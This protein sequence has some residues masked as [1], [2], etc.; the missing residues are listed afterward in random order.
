MTTPIVVL[1]TNWG[2]KHGGLNSFNIDLCTHLAGILTDKYKV[3]CVVLNADDS[4]IEDARGRGVHLLS[5]KADNT[6][7]DSAMAAEVIDSI[8]ESYVQ[9]AAWWVGHDIFTGP[10]AVKAANK[11]AGSRSAVLLHMDYK[12]YYVFKSGQGKSALEKGE[13][14][15]KVLND[16]DLVMAVGPN[17]ASVAREYVGPENKGK[18]VELIPGLSEVQKIYSPENFSAITF[19]RFVEGNEVIKQVKLA[20][21]AFAH[22]LKS[23]RHLFITSSPDP[24]FTVFGL[25]DGNLKEENTDLIKLA[26][27]YADRL[28]T[29]N[30]VPYLENRQQLFDQLASH[31]VCLI[32]S[33]HEGFGLA[34]LEA[35]SAEVP[36]ILSRA[37]GLYKFISE[38]LGKPGLGCLFEVDIKGA[39]DDPYFRPE[40]LEA[41]VNQ[42]ARIKAD[43][44]AAKQG[45]TALKKLLSDRGFTWEQTATQLAKACNLECNPAMGH[46]GGQAP[47]ER[48]TTPTGEGCT[49]PAGLGLLAR[50][51]HPKPCKDFTGRRQDLDRF[52]QAFLEYPFVVIEG[53]GGTGKTEFVT[54]CLKEFVDPERAVWFECSAESRFDLLIEASGYHDLLQGEKSDLAKYSGFTDLIERD[55]KVLFIDNYQD[56]TD[57]SLRAAFLFAARRLNQARVVLITRTHPNL[58]EIQYTPVRL[59]GLN[60]VNGDAFEFAKKLAARSYSH[61]T[62]QD[63]L[64]NGVC[65]KLAGHPLAIQL[66]LQLLSYGQSP[67]NILKSIVQD[68]NR[69]EDLSKRLL[70]IIFEHPK[71]TEQEKQFMLAFSVF[72]LK[73]DRLAIEALFEEVDI[74]VPLHGLID[75]L[76]ITYSPADC[77]YETHPLIREFCY[78]RLPEKKDFH[79]KAASHFASRR[80]PQFNPA[81]EERIYH[82]HLKSEIWFEIAAT[83]A[84]KG[85]E[86]V[87][88]GHTGILTEM[89]TVARKN[90]TDLAEFYLRE[91]DI[92][93]I[94]GEWNKALKCFETAFSCP[95]V[96]EA[97]TAEAYTKYGIIL[98][99]KGETRAAEDYFMEALVN[100]TQNNDRK[101]KALCLNSIGAVNEIYGN[102]KEAEEN[103]AAAFEI[104]QQIGDRE[105]A[106]SSLRSLGGIHATK[107]EIDGALTQ[108]RKSLDICEKIGDRVGIGESINCIGSV[109]LSKGDFDDALKK[110]IESLEIEKEIGDKSGISTSLNSVGLVLYSKGEFDGALEKFT[111][112]LVIDKEIGNK[113]G[114]AAS[115][116]NIGLVLTAKGDYDDAIKKYTE[117][118]AIV[119]DIG[120]KFGIATSLHNIGAVLRQ[121]NDA[122]G[123]LKKF[124]ESLEIVTEIGDRS[125]IAA[126]LN[127]IGLVLHS[128][129]NYDGAL[130]KFNESLEIQKRIGNKSAIA[131]YL[132]NIGLVLDSKGDSEG[133]LIKYTESLELKKEI[134]SR[135]TMTETYHNIGG[136]YERKSQPSS[137]IEMF[138]LCHALK[139]QM[140]MPTKNSLKNILRIRQ[141][142]KNLKQFTSIVQEAY[143]KIPVELQPFL[144]IDEL[145]MDNTV[146]HEIGER[147]G[148]NDP[149]PCGSG[150]KYKKCCQKEH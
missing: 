133:A 134:G 50:T 150:K 25:T 119:K 76:M 46:E 142:S 42:L 103:I 83:V 85:E 6:R 56:V 10:V 78:D 8:R 91:G 94:R 39:A 100:C 7:F 120:N 33:L 89:I 40:D 12:A 96:S 106:A 135:S 113:S 70:D 128:K 47:L 149:C 138:L 93:N 136:I 51:V 109:L 20:V 5:I 19:G 101:G 23:H 125:A 84:G 72:Q 86:F 116:N 27:R 66:A 137:A 114:I 124:T 3:V 14:Q 4:E 126:S 43:Y 108:Y 13:E 26:E 63:D 15:K 61:L 60:V 130:K 140:G 80:T 58:G 36:L 148:R 98:F 49:Q 68:K 48:H 69:S 99:R 21:A 22:A 81:L 77:L 121:K 129:G 117:S 104:R 29:I 34:G 139:Q 55:K 74:S 18:V 64:L 132:N 146:R 145:A 11:S 24:R 38:S 87:R 147:I 144:N 17:L 110:F 54:M 79:Q 65:E 92:D 123:A 131:T 118:L 30:G 53:Y 107:G 82:H 111:E 1:N 28:V 102:L 57:G 112:C 67:E 31:S 9:D 75:K 44:P 95:E 52:Q 97:V 127:N 115:L 41:V 16:A 105:G 71:S 59:E 141:T 2:N 32:L 143:S 62:V 35:I 122:A 45:A 88:R 73:V 90:G 37:S